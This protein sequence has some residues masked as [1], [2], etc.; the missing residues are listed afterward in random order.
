VID[1]VGHEVAVALELEA[2]LG[3]RG[4]ERGLDIR[5]DDP[6]RVGIEVVEKAALAILEGF[7]VFA[8]VRHR[9]VRLR[10]AY[11]VRCTSFEKDA[12]GNVAVVHCTYDPATRSGTPGADARKVKGN[13][14]WLAVGDAVQAEVRRYDRLFGVSFPGARNTGSVKDETAGA[15]DPLPLHAHLVAGDEDEVAEAAERSYL[16]DLDP[17]SKRVITACVEPALAAAP[18]E[19][20]VQFERHGYFV[21]DRVLHAAGSAVFNRTATLR[22]SWAR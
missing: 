9:V 15:A 20:R 8:R 18:A 5:A 13:I 4:R 6:F 2:L 12:A 21:A 14:H 11:V 1:Q 16:D 19:E 22:D 3:L 17:A 10:Y 7:V